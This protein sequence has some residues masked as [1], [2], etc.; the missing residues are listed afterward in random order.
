[1]TQR[2]NARKDPHHSWQRSLPAQSICWLSSFSLMSSGFVLA[3]SESAIDNIVPTAE[4]SQP[5]QNT[6]PTVIIERRGTS[7]RPESSPNEFSSRRA[8]LRQRLNRNV[9]QSEQPVRKSRPDN[10]ASEPV[11]RIRQSRAKVETEVVPAVRK[12]RPKVAERR[13]PVVPERAQTQNPVEAPSASRVNGGEEKTQVEITAPVAPKT[14][15]TQL[16]EVAQTNKPPVSDKN[17]TAEKPKDYNNAYIDPTDYSAGN[18]GK[19]ESPNSVVITDRS[20]SCRAGVGQTVPANCVKAPVTASIRERLTGSKTARTQ[21]TAPSWI[22]KS[23]SINVATT[24]TPRRT[25]STTETNSGWRG[26]RIAAAS[27]TRV[28]DV[29]RSTPRTSLPTPP[30]AISSNKNTYHPNR[31]IPHPSNFVPQPTTIS[32]TP[33]A[34]SGGVLPLPMTAEN[35]APRPSTVAYNIPLES[36]LPRVTY[37]G[38][39]YNPTGFIFPTS[40]PAPITSIFGW[41][42]HPITGDVRFHSGADIGAAMG[43]PVLA[44]YTGQVEVSDFVGGYGLTV[45]L[46]HNNAVQTLYGHM[47]QLYVQP[48]QWVQQGTV[49]GLVGSTGNSTGPHL[50]FEVRQ[51]TQEGWVA[52]DPGVHLQYALTQLMQSMQT[53]QAP[54]VQPNN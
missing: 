25:T 48:G 37:N 27:N 15:P 30:V 10:Q 26:S 39:G 38:M 9:A 47:S 23:Q 1:M 29:T 16:P 12:L 50:H 32:A 14:I 53:A 41:R 52:T 51:L 20:G 36:T 31:F 33:I 17:T 4:N 19:Y 42:K 11:R 45:I 8:K 44:A 2:K 5:S 46:N 43:T 35:T 49:I 54:Q 18:T 3:Q 21:A 24:I 28:V 7:A 13:D 22:R 34:P 40:V 6:A